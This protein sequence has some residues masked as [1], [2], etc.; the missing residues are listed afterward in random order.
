MPHMFIFSQRVVL[1]LTLLAAAACSEVD[2]SCEPNGDVTPI[3]GVQ[4]PEDLEPLPGAGGIL[5]GEYG[6]GGQLPGALTWSQPAAGRTFTRLVE[7]SN[8][9]TGA[10]D[11]N[12]GAADCTL[13]DLLSPHGIHL[14]TH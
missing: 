14:S 13:P 7:S 5:I 8:I 9:T 10:S 11:Q 1:L 2:M 12:W 3:C 4:M 6:D